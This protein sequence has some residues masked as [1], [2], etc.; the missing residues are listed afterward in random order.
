MHKEGLFGTEGRIRPLKDSHMEANSNREKVDRYGR[1]YTRELV[2]GAKEGV[3]DFELFMELHRRAAE[4][5]LK[6][7]TRYD[8]D[9]EVGYSN[10]NAV[11]IR[12]YDWKWNIIQRGGSTYM[13]ARGEVLR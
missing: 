2:D 9:D 10:G 5:Y 1:M 8:W 11:F 4:K 3:K 7:N 6:H 13:M 12:N